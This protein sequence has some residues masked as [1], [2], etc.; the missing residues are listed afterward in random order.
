MR[1][2]LLAYKKHYINPTNELITEGLM[3][4]PGV[5]AWGPGYS[6]VEY[7]SVVKFNRQK[8]PFDIVIVNS[9]LWYGDRNGIWSNLSQ[10]KKPYN[11]RQFIEAFPDWPKGIY[12]L[13]VPIIV[14]NLLDD[15]HGSEQDFFEKIRRGDTYVLSTAANHQIVRKAGSVPFEK[16]HFL[17]GAEY[18]FHHPEVIDRKRYLLCPHCVADSEF[19]NEGRYKYDVAIPGT[20]YLFRREAIEYLSSGRDKRTYRIKHL[21]NDL[22]LAIGSVLYSK[23]V[24]GLHLPVPSDGIGEMIYKGR[25]R[26]VVSHSLV[27]I[28][29]SSLAGYPIRKFFEIPAFGSVLVANFFDHPDILGFR[30]GINCFSV[31]YDSLEKIP[32]IIDALKRDRAYLEGIRKSGYKLIRNYHTVNI[33]LNQ[34]MD[35]ARAILSGGFRGTKWVDG[36]QVILTSS[37]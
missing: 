10:V 13:D 1:A 29:C 35:V 20:R 32:T 5:T 34:I 15:L 8:G 23:R 30:D 37:E 33:R 16:E 28:T 21:R 3:K 6:S 31:D 26:H 25:F 18:V 11:G 9:V 36:K 27:T 19:L 14:L 7:D 24:K 22:L 12:D 2:L 17:T 4:Y